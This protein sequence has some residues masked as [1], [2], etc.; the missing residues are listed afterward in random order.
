MDTPVGYLITSQNSLIY[1][2]A[3]A[4]FKQEIISFTMACVLWSS[5]RHSSTVLRSSVMNP[6]RFLPSGL[7]GRT[8]TLIARI[9]MPGHRSDR[10]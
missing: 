1:Q 3:A 5:S 6:R 7:C 2:N 4:R 9:V 10:S 8:P